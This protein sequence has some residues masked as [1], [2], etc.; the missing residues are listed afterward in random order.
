VNFH[1][2]VTARGQ[3]GGRASRPPV[4]SSF[5]GRDRGAVRRFPR[6]FRV[7]VA[8]RLIGKDDARV[9]DQ[10]AAIATTLLL[11]ARD[12]AGKCCSRSFRPTSTS[13]CSARHGLDP[14]PDHGWQQHVF[15]R[16]EF[17]QQKVALEDEA[18]GARCESAPDGLRAA[19]ELRAFKTRPCAD[20]VSQ[21]RR[22]CRAASSCRRQT[23][24]KERP[25]R[26]VNLGADSRNTSIFGRQVERSGRRS[27]AMTGE[28]RAGRPGR[29]DRR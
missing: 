5:R 3:V 8:G 20:S 22:A 21:P 2:A 13:A 6:P 9:I 24:R 4:S 25:L 12:S 19:V 7:E 29:W 27:K 15:E 10:R 16:G 14:L 28:K 1:A 17:R 26:R 11:A 18:D 23:R